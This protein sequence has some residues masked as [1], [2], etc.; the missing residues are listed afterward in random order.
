MS[1][2]AAGSGQGGAVS[3][4]AHLFDL[5]EDGAEDV[6]FVVGDVAGEIGEV[7]RVLH[8]AG[9]ALE[10]H[11]GIDVLGGQGGEGAVGVGVELDEDQVPDFDA[12]GVAFVDQRAFGVARGGEIDVHFGA[13]T[14][15]AGFAHHPE[16]V[17]LVAVDDVDFRVEAGGA[18]FLGP[19]VVGFLVEFAGVALVWPGL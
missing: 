10:A 19:A 7:L 16:V 1:P 15:G 8:D 2:V 4:A 17:L 12:R 11:A 13:R 14:A 18:E 3:L 5:V 6:G 9:D